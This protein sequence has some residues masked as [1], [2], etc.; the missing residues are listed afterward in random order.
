MAWTE[1][2]VADLKQRQEITTP[3]R[4]NKIQLLIL[5]TDDPGDA[6]DWITEYGPVPVN[7]AVCAIQHQALKSMGFSSNPSCIWPPLVRLE[8]KNSIPATK[9]GHQHAN[10]KKHPPLRPL[11]KV[12]E[13]Y[14]VLRKSAFICPMM[15]GIGTCTQSEPLPL[16]TCPMAFFEDRALR[17]KPGS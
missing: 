4:R 6:P 13:K 12:G 3:D 2:E 10:R 11:K 1:C 15:Q 17:R 9:Y 16:Q 14:P 8:L 7:M 5:P